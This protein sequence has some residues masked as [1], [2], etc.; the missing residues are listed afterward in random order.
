MSIQPIILC[1]ALVA[2][3]IH[4]ECVKIDN[5]SALMRGSYSYSLQSY[6]RYPLYMMQL[7]RDFSG[8]MATTPARLD[9]PTLQ[10]SDFVLSL[11]AQGKT[12]THLALTCLAYFVCKIKCTQAIK[13]IV[14]PYQNGTM[15]LYIHVWSM[16]GC[17][18]K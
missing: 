16:A 7:Y 12:C 6:P 9:S 1:A 8:K 11:I 4:V 10:Q 5:P 14:P 17:S 15:V 13:T 3:L 2:L 18:W